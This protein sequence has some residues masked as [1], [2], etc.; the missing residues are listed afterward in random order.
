MV[1]LKE[2]AH[3]DY[4]SVISEERSWRDQHFATNLMKIVGRGLVDMAICI[5]VNV[6][7]CWP[8]FCKP[9]HMTENETY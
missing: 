2:Y 7:L 1:K 6:C 5:F 9:C 3:K 4:H 8:P